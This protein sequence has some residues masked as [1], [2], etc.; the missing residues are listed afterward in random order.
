[1]YPFERFTVGAKRV[2]TLAQQ[3]AE[4]SHHSYIGTEHLVIALLVED[5]GP[6]AQVLAGLGVGLDET[7]ERIASMLGRNER[8]VIQQII[9]TS[10]VKKVI[11]LSFEA[12]KDIGDD[13]VDTDH[14]LL[15]LVREG[16]GLAARVLA[17]QGATLEALEDA[18]AKLRG[19]EA[20]R[21]FTPSTPPPQSG[22]AAAAALP[23]AM[24]V[25]D[26]AS[27][28]A[29][30]RGEAMSSEHVLLALSRS[31]WGRAASILAGHGVTPDAIEE[32]LARP[33]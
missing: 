3:E 28:I 26:A 4:R 2:L 30:E 14:L 16:Q 13:A 31:D 25:L 23:S 17:E 20:A 22:A 7:R 9:P 6:G 27:R 21:R 33:E 11:E 1:M 32:S 19:P 15:G 10:R 24:Q 12:A 5:D 18:V 29:R 8:L